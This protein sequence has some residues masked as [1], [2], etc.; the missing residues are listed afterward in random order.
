MTNLSLLP[1]ELMACGCPVV[2][3][4]GPHVEWLLNSQNSELADPTVEALAGGLRKVLFDKERR[5]ALIRNGFETSAAT[6]WKKEAAKVATFL[7]ELAA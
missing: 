2:S 7:N 1:L 6:D 5:Q 4:N 3:N